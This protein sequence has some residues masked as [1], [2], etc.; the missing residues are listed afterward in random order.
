[1]RPR[2]LDVLSGLHEVVLVRPDCGCGPGARAR[3]VKDVLQVVPRR[4]GCQDAEAHGDLLVGLSRGE[5]QQDLE[6]PVR[7]S[8]RH[9][10]WSF[11][12]PMAGRGNTVAPS[13][14]A[15]CA[16]RH[17]WWRT[18]LRNGRSPQPSS[19]LG[20]SR[21]SLRVRCLRADTEVGASI[22][23]RRS[24]PHRA[25]ALY[26]DRVAMRPCSSRPSPVRTIASVMS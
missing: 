14:R 2:R 11:L 18:P 10:A 16:S 20:T 9:L 7:Q 25:I 3:L 22:R 15:A 24:S 26:E 8:R 19:L 1:M 12:H 5:R 17:P 23:R 6:F 4:L 13:S 21:P